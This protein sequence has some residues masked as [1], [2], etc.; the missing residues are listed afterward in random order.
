V[1]HE[2][3]Q[4]LTRVPALADEEVA[5]IA[6]VRR[7]VVRRELL[8]AR[9]LADRVANAVAGVA[10]QPAMLDLEHLVPAPGPVQ[11]ERRPVLEL[12]ERVL[13]LVAVVELRRRW[14]NLFERRFRKPGEPLQRVGDPLLLRSELRAVREV[15]EAAAAARRVVRA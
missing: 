10:R 11:A 6:L 15:L 9:P 4:R 2:L 8:L 1:R 14:E 3:H 12:R 5:E 13:H 7:L